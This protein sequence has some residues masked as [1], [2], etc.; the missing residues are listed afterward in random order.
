MTAILIL[1][2]AG[3]LAWFYARFLDKQSGE[4][5]M[6]AGVLLLVPFAVIAIGAI[7][8]LVAWS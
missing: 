1:L 4:V 7:V 6:G 2:V 5:M 3:L 8:A